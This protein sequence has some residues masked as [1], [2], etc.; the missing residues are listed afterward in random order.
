MLNSCQNHVLFDKQSKWLYHN[1]EIH[2][3]SMYIV[4]KIT[5]I[6]QTI[7]LIFNKIQFSYFVQFPAIL[8]ISQ[9][10]CATLIITYQCH[11]ITKNTLKY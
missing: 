1:S 3:F 11:L 10:I 2:M 9:G 5:L 6:V 8:T 7:V 4:Y